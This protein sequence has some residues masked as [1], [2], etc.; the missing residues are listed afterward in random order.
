MKQCVAVAVCLLAL[1]VTAPAESRTEREQQTGISEEVFQQAERILERTLGLMDNQVDVSLPHAPAA[2][3]DMQGLRNI[4]LEAQKDAHSAERLSAIQ[5]VLDNAPDIIDNPQSQAAIEAFA[6]STEQN[7]TDIEN[8]MLGADAMAYSDELSQSVFPTHGNTVVFLSV[9]TPE[10]E[11]RQV[12]EEA[13]YL[14]GQGEL[15][16]V[17]I[18]GMKEEHENLYES[19]FD[20]IKMT[21]DFDPVPLLLLE[22]GLFEEHDI[23]QAPQV[24]VFDRDN[25]IKARAGGINSPITVLNAIDQHAMAEDAEWPLVIDQMANA[26][27][28]RERSVVERII[29]S[30][31]AMDLE[32]QAKESLNTYWSRYDFINTLGTATRSDVFQIDP[33]IRIE[34]D[35]QDPYSGRYIRRA[36]DLINPLH[37]RPFNTVLIVFDARDERQVALAVEAQRRAYEEHSGKRIMMLTTHIDPEIENG[38]GH[39]PILNERFNDQTYLIQPEIVERF[40]IHATPSIVTADRDFYYVE[41]VSIHEAP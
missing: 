25:E 20:L 1:G 3:L 13:S 29:A 32:A 7:W 22:P 12:L 23:T 30:Y 36:G 21:A 34:E 8:R 41:E 19:L 4:L 17:V 2:Q 5:R 10:H 24:L 9:Y 26:E 31:A 6:H 38:W 28:I 14:H 15:V 18:R 39:W 33:T 27:P 35:I 37:I 16:R 40:Q 11:L